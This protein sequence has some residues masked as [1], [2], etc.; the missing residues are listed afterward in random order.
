MIVASIISDEELVETGIMQYVLPSFRPPQ[1]EWQI[2]TCKKWN[3]QYCNIVNYTIA[4]LLD[5][6]QSLYNF[7]PCQTESIPGDGNCYF[8]TISYLITGTRIY[9][10]ELRA[11]LVE[12]ML[13]KLSANCNIFLRTKYIYT[14]KVIIGMFKIG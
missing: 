2:S 14:H 1:V 12:N 8:S 7:D 10:K 9:H 4:D 13:G 6:D 5:K 3:L 11:I